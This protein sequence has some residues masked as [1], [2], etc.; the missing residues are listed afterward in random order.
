[1]LEGRVLRASDR[2]GEGET[3]RE[4]KSGRQ[5]GEAEGE[6]EGENSEARY[7][8]I[9]AQHGLSEVPGRDPRRP[10]DSTSPLLPSLINALP[11]RVSTST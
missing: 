2:H 7:F 9:A 3:A 11:L 4:G 8:G 1:M 5:E 10:S 6:R